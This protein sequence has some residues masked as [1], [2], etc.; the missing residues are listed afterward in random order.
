MR[1]HRHLLPHPPPTPPHPTP[2]HPG[3]TLRSFAAPHDGAT[4]TFHAILR[5]EYGVNCTIRSEKGQVR[6]L[7]QL[8]LPLLVPLPLLLLRC[9]WSFQGTL[10]E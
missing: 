4:A 6:L 5:F 7:P 3:S 9:C 1:H 2:P 10:N 8:Q